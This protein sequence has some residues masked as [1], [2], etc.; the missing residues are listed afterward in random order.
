MVE[1]NVAQS[2]IEVVFNG[3]DVKQFDRIEPSTLRK[4]LDI[5]ASTTVISCLSRFDEFK[6]NQ[7]LIDSIELLKQRNLITRNSYLF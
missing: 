4:E 3:V 7:F 2:K 6:G 5:D 1:N